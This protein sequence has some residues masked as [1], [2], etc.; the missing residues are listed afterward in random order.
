MK[1]T[2][3]LSGSGTNF[4]AILN[5]IDQGKLSNVTIQKVIADREC[6]GINRAIDYNI[7][8]TIV[9]RKNLENDLQKAIPSDTDLI[10]LA[11]FLSIL[12]QSIIEQFPE[13]IINIHPSLLPKFGGKGMYGM[14]V[15]NAVIAAGEQESG[16]TVHFVNE[17]I[18]T[19]KIILQYKVPVF[20]TDTAEQLQ[21]RVLKQEHL[22]F[23]KAIQHLAKAK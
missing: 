16:C 19:G 17:G 3:L 10:V 7:P 22:A 12:P 11:G 9:Q 14:N 2:V 20:K 15:H 1:L 23:P 18:D 21:K 5:A 6:Q 13:K 4:Q 8:F